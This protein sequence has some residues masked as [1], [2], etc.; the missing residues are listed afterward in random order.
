MNSHPICNAQS[1]YT[2]QP[3]RAVWRLLEQ[4]LP[5]PQGEQLFLHQS[6]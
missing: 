1:D 4:Q 3:P 2:L 6:H 5:L